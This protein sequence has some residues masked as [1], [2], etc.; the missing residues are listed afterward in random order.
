MSG[1]IDSSYSAYVLKQQGYRVVG[2]TFALLPRSMTNDRNPKACCSSESTGRARKVADDLSIP[3]YVINLRREFEELV[4]DRFVSEYRSGRTPNPCVLCNQHIKF[5][6]FMRTALALGADAVATGHYAAIEQSAEGWLLKKGKDK[7]KDQSY[8]LYPV[9]RE[10]LQWLL[11]P[12]A[13][14]TKN[15]VRLNMTG[16]AL[17]TSRVA[18]SQDICFIPDSDYRRFMGA[19]V[20]PA[21]GRVFLSD[22][23]HIGSH[24]GVHLYTVGQRRGINIPYPEPLYVLEINPEENALIVGP[25]EALRRRRLIA[26]DINMFTGRSSGRASARVRYRQKEEACTYEVADDRLHITFDDPVSAVTP[27]QSVV[28]YEGDTVLGGGTI[29]TA[30]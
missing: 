11:F 26:G 17:D 9:Q 14:T 3:H 13:A 8:F 19:H 15:E 4:I 28:V 21:R 23:T 25:K 12:L 29:S 1:G 20:S 7:I 27:G 6:G 22:G 16:K 2:V 10:S 5:S 30:S 24:E 18:E